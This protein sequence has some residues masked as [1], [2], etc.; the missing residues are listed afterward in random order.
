MTK[1]N[2]QIHSLCK[3]HI[4]AIEELSVTIIT[5]AVVSC[6]SLLHVKACINDEVCLRWTLY[7]FFSND[8][9]V[10]GLACVAR[11]PTISLNFECDISTPH[12]AYTKYVLTATE[13]RVSPLLRER[14]DLF[15]RLIFVG[16]AGWLGTVK[17]NKLTG[18]VRLGLV[19]FVFFNK[20]YCQ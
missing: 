4:N 10:Y 3:K 19:W 17:M 9:N 7:F 13:T 1:K 14:R 11:G 20:K 16:W 12:S 5:E 6:Y 15:S 2:F 18:W 8:L